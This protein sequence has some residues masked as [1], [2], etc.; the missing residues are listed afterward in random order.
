M[1]GL[2]WRIEYSV[3]AGF[4]VTSFVS[5]FIFGPELGFSRASNWL[6]IAI[7]VVIVGDQIRRSP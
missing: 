4:V 5:P 7:L 1:G 2:K 3:A 6:L